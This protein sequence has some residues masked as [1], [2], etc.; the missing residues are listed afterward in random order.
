MSETRRLIFIAPNYVMNSATGRAIIKLETCEMI[1]FAHYSKKI[2]I[3]LFKEVPR[4]VFAVSCSE[5]N[6]F[7]PDRDEIIG[8]SQSDFYNSDILKRVYSE[9]ELNQYRYFAIK[10]ACPEIP[11]LSFSAGGKTIN[12]HLL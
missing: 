5:S 3:G 9:D 4:S 7:D 2:P 8:C 11:I 12:S 6:H 10:Q 1:K